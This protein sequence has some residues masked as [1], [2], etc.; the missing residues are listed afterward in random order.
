M[1]RIEIR[2]HPS[3]FATFK[4]HS[5]SRWMIIPDIS[6]F[7]S[8]AGLEQRRAPRTNDQGCAHGGPVRKRCRRR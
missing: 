4:F 6:H 1:T 2:A 8:H 3:S 7:Y 5:S